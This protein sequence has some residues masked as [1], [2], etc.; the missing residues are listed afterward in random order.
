[1]KRTARKLTRQSARWEAQFWS[2]SVSREG[3]LNCAPCE[4]RHVQRSD[5]A[6]DSWHVQKTTSIRQALYLNIVFLSP[7]RTESTKQKELAEQLKKKLAEEPRAKT[8]H[9]GR[10]PISVDRSNLMYIYFWVSGLYNC[11]NVAFWLTYSGLNS[12]QG[13]TMNRQ[14]LSR[15]FMKSLGRFSNFDM[16]A[17]FF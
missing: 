5:C 2:N 15:V 14:I 7:D 10:P 4:S 1:M 3:G 6:E 17:A 8:F 12:F 11:Q 13:L 16:S 9:Q